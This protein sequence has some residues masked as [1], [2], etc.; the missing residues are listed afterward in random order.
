MAVVHRW[1]QLAARM[2]IS[3]VNS[4]TKAII[5]K[6]GKLSTFTRRALNVALASAL[7]LGASGLAVNAYA[8]TANGTATAT[9]ITPIGVSTTN[10]LVFGS[11]A[12]GAASG[13][14]TVYTN[15]TRATTGPILSTVGATPAAAIFHVTGDGVSTYSI[16]TAGTATTIA[17]G[18]NNMTFAHCTALTAAATC[19]PGSNVSSGTLVAGAQ[20][21]YMGGT[22]TVSATQVAAT[23]YTGAISVTVE[24]N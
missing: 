17:S 20:D 4:I 5:M 7:V 11:F 9:V 18:A 24:Y 21:I 14:V 12:H 10:S 1:Q 22:L 13:D 15:G 23:D 3:E 2:A 6:S 16:T 8:A 19:V